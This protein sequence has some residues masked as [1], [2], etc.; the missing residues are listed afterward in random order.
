MYV[1][2]NGAFAL[3]KSRVGKTSCS[4]AEAGMAANANGFVHAIQSGFE[5]VFE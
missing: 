5:H 1:A 3:Q 2:E 4:G